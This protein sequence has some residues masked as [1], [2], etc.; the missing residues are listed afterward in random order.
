MDSREWIDALG[1][2]LA[3]QKGLLHRLLDAIEPDQRWEWLELGCS[4]ADGRGDALSDLDMALGHAGE[5]A[6]PVDDVTA[7]LRALGP[8]VD[9]AARPWDGFTRWWVQYT[10]GGQIDLVVL[11]AG[12]RPGRAPR[13]VALLDRTG[14]LAEEFTPSALRP[15]PEDPGHWL[16]DGW[17]ALA[18]I[19]KYLA[20]G[21]HLE[22]A[23][24]LHRVRERI[25]Q[26]WAVGEGIDYPAF[27]L[28]SLL[29]FAAPPPGI[30]ATYAPPT[31]NAVRAAALASAELLHRAGLHARPGLDTPLREWV[32]RRLAR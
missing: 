5:K 27:G 21:S 6:P 22:A 23:E 13:S 9:C 29:D 31:A 20:R 7:L 30:A 32:T 1:P 3:V 17:E 12:R 24:Q 15:S 11:P 2:A 18:N 10:D 16:L 8:V 14:R 19:H 28:T 26:L 4:V 25:C